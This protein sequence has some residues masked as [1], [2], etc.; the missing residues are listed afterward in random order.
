MTVP[1]TRRV[2]HIMGMPILADVR[3]AGD[4]DD[5]I[6]DLYRWFR[7]VDARFSTYRDESEIS[8]YNRGELRPSD[9]GDE[10]RWVLDRCEELRLETKGY[11]DVRAETPTVVDPSGLVKGWAVARGAAILEQAGLRHFN[12]NAGGDIVVRGGALP[13]ASWRIGIQHPRSP[14]KIAEVVVLTDGAIATSGAYARG[15]HVF[16]PHTG[17]PPSGLLSVS[18]VGPDL[19]TADA[20]ATAVFAMGSDGPGWS[21]RLPQL[22]YE[23]MSIT[24]DDRVLCTPGFPRGGADQPVAD[25]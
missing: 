4:H 8:R 13:E 24:E 17:R 25:A 10:L 1:G 22:G 3:D 5:P 7:D 21:A 19:A 11:F 20:Y 12:V 15:D 16:D 9:L 23:A 18:I 2:E 14:D 6:E